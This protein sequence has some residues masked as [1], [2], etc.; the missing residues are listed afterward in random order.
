MQWRT[1]RKHKILLSARKHVSEGKIFALRRCGDQ[2]ENC[3]NGVMKRPGRRTVKGGKFFDT[4]P[5]FSVVWIEKG[6]T[7]V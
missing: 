3:Q 4:E 5:F 7:A 1:A 2:E 6:E